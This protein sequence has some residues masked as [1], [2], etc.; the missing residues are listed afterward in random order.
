MDGST[1][2]CQVSTGQEQDWKDLYNSAFPA[3]ERTPLEELQRLLDAGSILLH[4]TT[5]KSGEL[6]CFSIVYPMSNFALL[7][8]I[9]SDS[10]KR[11]TGIGSK[12][13]KRLL[14]ILKSGYPEFL[15]LVLEIEST[16]QHGLEAAEKTARQRRL[17]F[18]QRL[19]AKR[20]CRT[21][22][23]PSYSLKGTYRLAEL[24]WFDFDPATID[25]PHL[26][27]IIKELYTKGYGAQADDP[28]LEL[29]VHQFKC[30]DKTGSASVVCPV[31]PAEGD[32]KTAEKK[33]APAKAD[34]SAST[35]K[36][37]DAV[38]TDA[39]TPAKDDTTTVKT[40]V[41]TATPATTETAVVN[42]DPV[43]TAQT[44]VTTDN[45]PAPATTTAEPA[46]DKMST[47]APA[48]VPV[49]E[50]G[51][52]SKS[53]KTK[54]LK[55]KFD[56]TKPDQPVPITAPSPQGEEGGNKTKDGV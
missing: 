23:W 45:S 12:H 36:P 52:M 16:R 26:P 25:D 40:D 54:S 33:D 35:Q 9:A 20:L 28:I 43:Q 2:L 38:K 7:S 34:H 56:E 29:V 1:N 42:A 27:G 19:G 13:M 49:Q 14:E 41:V 47:D 37:A 18:Y 11:S 6:L 53:K 4:R 55:T 22:V 17:A 21:Y 10:T 39:V 24:M 48:A 50:K 44:P 32:K 31:E 15:G 46:A 8:Y 5:N 30:S 51:E 3:D